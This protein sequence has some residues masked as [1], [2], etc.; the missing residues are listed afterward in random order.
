M[1]IGN[2]F[3]YWFPF[4]AIVVLS[5]EQKKVRLDQRVT[6]GNLTQV[7]TDAIYNSIKTNHATCD[8]TGTAR[9]G[10]SM[11]AG[12]GQIK[13]WGKVW[14]KSWP[15]QRPWWWNGQAFSCGY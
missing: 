2:Q 7:Q 11:G 3:T 12:F 8:G 4:L 13:V 14:A 15:R 10:S 6:D 1:S 9:T 5:L